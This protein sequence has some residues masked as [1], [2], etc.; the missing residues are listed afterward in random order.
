M[1]HF[2]VYQKLAQYCELTICHK[3]WFHYGTKDNQGQRI[4]LYIEY[5]SLWKIHFIALVFL[6]LLWMGKHF[7]MDIHPLLG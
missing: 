7:I 4:I 2:A 6:I 3:I 5:C 1:N